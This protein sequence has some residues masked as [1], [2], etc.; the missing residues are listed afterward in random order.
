MVE[1]R[2]TAL[3]ASA[4][5]PPRSLNPAAVG[6]RPSATIARLVLRGYVLSGWVWGEAV[7]VVA[8]FLIFWWYAGDE[9]YFFGAA[10]LCLGA[11]TIVGT[12]IMTHR[13]LGPH[14][15]LPLARLDSRAAYP[16]GLMLA[17]GTLRVAWICLLT[18]LALLDRKIDNP[19]PVGMLAGTAGLVANC[20]V[21]TAATLALSP[22]IATR[23]QRIVFLA[24]LV[25]ALGSFHYGGPLSSTLALAQLPLR[26]LGI[27][28]S[29]GTLSPAPTAWS[30]LL[31][32]LTEFLYIV[33]IVWFAARSLARRDLVHL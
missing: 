28:F 17:A 4:A 19:T 23:L 3:P 26:P 33:V 1:Q 14:A 7:I 32:L 2:Q 24:W 12:V 13:A 10:T 15:A 11:L 29:L 16:V 31:A 8:F 5:R 6:R 22:P 18:L 25:I 27:S 21:L 20:L 9:S 30:A